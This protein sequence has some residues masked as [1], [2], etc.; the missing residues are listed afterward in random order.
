MGFLEQNTVFQND[1]VSDRVAPP[2]LQGPY[3]GAYLKTIGMQLDA[4]QYKSA[5]GQLLHMPGMGDPSANYYIGLDRV[6]TQGQLGETEAQFVV[7]LTQAFDTWQ[8]AGNDWAV[9]QQVLAQLLPYTPACFI[10]SNT[11]RWS[12][13]AAGANPNEPP[14]SYVYGGNPLNSWNWDNNASD[15]VLTGI[16]PWWRIWLCIYSV[17]PNLW[18]T[19]WATLGN[20]SLPT[21]GSATAQL[22]SLGFSNIPPSF[23]SNLRAILTPY[24]AVH[25]WIRWILVSFSSTIFGQDQ[26]AGGPT[27]NPNGTWASGFAITGG[28]YGSTWGALVCP[29]QGLPAPLSGNVGPSFDYSATFGFRIVSGQYLAA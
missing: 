17:A 16:K 12:W 24:K 19:P 23:W 1:I 18:A 8:H 22:G 28:Q 2:W 20:G 9:L 5:Q 6:L 7:R 14:S 13:Y 21:L 3:G 25:A 11:A 10:V 26:P 29:V 27:G 4:L 15:P